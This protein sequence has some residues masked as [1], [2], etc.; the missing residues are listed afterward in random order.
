MIYA[1]RISSTTYVRRFHLSLKRFETDLT[2]ISTL[3]CAA[4]RFRS[5]LYSRVS[6]S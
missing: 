4:R 2:R 3:N 5:T 1:K 6:I